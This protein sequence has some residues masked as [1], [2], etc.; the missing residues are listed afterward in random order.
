MAQ[1]RLVIIMLM[2]N[3]ILEESFKKAQDIVLYA[4]ENQ[5]RPEFVNRIDEVIVFRQLDQDP[6]YPSLKHV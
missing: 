2:Q 1:N 5:L 3:W 4:I 6:C